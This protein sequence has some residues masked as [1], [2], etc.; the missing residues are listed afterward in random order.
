MMTLFAACEKESLEDTYKE[1]AGE[2]EIRYMGKCTDLLVSPG[3]QRLIVTW[4]NNVD[5]VIKNYCCPMKNFKLSI[6]C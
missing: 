6:I 4:E 5:P 3:W 1:Y 2:G